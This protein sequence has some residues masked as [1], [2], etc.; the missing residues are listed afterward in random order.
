MDHGLTGLTEKDIK[1]WCRLYQVVIGDYATALGNALNSGKNDSPEY[2]TDW[3]SQA[4]SLCL[5]LKNS[6]ASQA[7]HLLRAYALIREIE[8]RYLSNAEAI[9]MR[10]D[11]ESVHFDSKQYLLIDTRPGP[12]YHSINPNF[13]L[14]SEMGVDAQHDLRFHWQVLPE[15]SDVQIDR[16]RSL[17]GLKN[18]GSIRVGLAPFSTASEQDWQWDE[19]NPRAD[20]AWPL[21]CQGV[22]VGHD[23]ALR[24][25]LQTV[26]ELAHESNV[27]VLIL[28]E[29]CIDERQLAWLQAWLKQH[30]L[31]KPVLRQVIAGSCHQ[32][33]DEGDDCSVGSRFVNR[34]TVLGQGGEILWQQDKT[35]PFHLDASQ[36]QAGFPSCLALSL[37]EPRH[38]GTRLVLRDTLIGRI[39]TPICIDLLN[40]PLTSQLGTDCYWVPAMSHSTDLFWDCAKANGR[41]RGAITLLVNA[42]LQG[43]QRT[44]CYLL[45]QQPVRPEKLGEHLYCIDFTFK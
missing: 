5:R 4:Q 24:T 33:V 22:L 14:K 41:S 29:L 3:G 2:V 1:A 25:R 7:Q 11:W 12:V 31:I 6:T 45:K 38:L 34:C 35:R 9:M 26:L 30:N 28:P 10:P 44:M 36:V 19:S 13:R 20:K 37:Y 16:C 15:E 21:R 32:S 18:E 27:H 8:S 42:Q 39:S 43:D 17:N 23:E 40:N